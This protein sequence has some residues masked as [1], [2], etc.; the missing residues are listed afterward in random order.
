MAFHWLSR[1]HLSL[2]RWL[3]GRRSSSF[4]LLEVESSLFLSGVRPAGPSPL[5]LEWVSVHES[6]V[7]SGQGRNALFC[8]AG[9]GLPGFQ[10]QLALPTSSPKRA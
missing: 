1:S 10:Y 2:A 6:S 5:Q 9:R 3:P 4:F 8:S 7:W